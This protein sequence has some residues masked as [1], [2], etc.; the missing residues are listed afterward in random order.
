MLLLDEKLPDCISRQRCDEF[1]TSFCYLNSKGARKKLVSAIIKVP[2]SR[3]ELTATY[4][5]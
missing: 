4:A 3:V 2:R 5:R 1:C